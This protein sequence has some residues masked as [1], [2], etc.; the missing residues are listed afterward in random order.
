MFS[1]GHHQVLPHC[2]IVAAHPI[3]LLLIANRRL[4][5]LIT[6]Q[7]T[8]WEEGREGETILHCL[9]TVVVIVL[10]GSCRQLA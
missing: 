6:N 1:G 10:S 3:S 7:G 8:H 5:V 9:L 2:F 4:P